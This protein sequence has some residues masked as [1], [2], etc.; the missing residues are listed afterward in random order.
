MLKNDYK[1]ALNVVAEKGYVTTMPLGQPLG[2]I[3][4]NKWH[5]PLLSFIDNYNLIIVGLL[6]ILCRN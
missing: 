5:L 6:L 4:I 3:I 2:R 1:C